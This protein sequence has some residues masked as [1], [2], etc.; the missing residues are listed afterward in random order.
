M[1]YNKTNFLDPN[2]KIVLAAASGEGLQKLAVWCKQL[3]EKCNDLHKESVVQ[4]NLIEVQKQT[5]DEQ[6]K[7][8]D[9]LK[10]AVDEQKL[11]IDDY[12]SKI[13]RLEALTA[14]HSI[15]LAKV[16]ESQLIGPSFGAWANPLFSSTNGNK[17]QLNDDAVQLVTVVSQEMKDIKKREKKIVI[18]GVAECDANDTNELQGD[19]ARKD[20]HKL[21]QEKADKET[22]NGILTAAGCGSAKVISIW[23]TKRIVNDRDGRALEKPISGKI[24]VELSSTS[25]HS[26]ILA[27]SKE[28]KKNDSFKNIYISRDLTPVE[29]AKL[30][31]LRL[32][33]NKRNCDS[34]QDT[35]KIWVIR[36]AK[37]V[38]VTRK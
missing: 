9:E 25:E 13:L 22:V 35:S 4:K 7:S 37:L 14:E 27:N 29:A 19:E 33:R 23:R 30:Y 31:Q 28:L 1:D 32:E 18:T 10:Q 21:Q 20:E 15:E 6:K 24:I 11:T 36:D 26:R 3:T 8:I 17:T 16:K 12:N 38:E 2:F 34:S 5:I